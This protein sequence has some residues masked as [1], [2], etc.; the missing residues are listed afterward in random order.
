M[1]RCQSGR[2]C[3]LGTAVYRN[4]PRVQ[5]PISAP[6]NSPFYGTFF[7]CWDWACAL[8]TIAF[9]NYLNLYSSLILS[10]SA[11]APK[12]IRFRSYRQ[13]PISAPIKTALNPLFFYLLERDLAS[14]TCLA[15]FVCLNSANTFV[16]GHS[17]VCN[18]HP[19]IAVHFALP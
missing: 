13:I 14:F 8:H 4:V 17:S 19:R 18:C 10:A 15:N 6:K 1:Q 5:I 11:L 9:S 7:I 3:S 12:Y 2:S 16:L